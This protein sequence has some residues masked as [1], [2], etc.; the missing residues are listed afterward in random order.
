LLFGL[1]GMM[2]MMAGLVLST[3][4]YYENVIIFHWNL[5]TQGIAGLSTLGIGIFLIFVSLILNSLGIL[6]EKRN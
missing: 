6:M 1:P 4:T 2:M 3:A 5:I